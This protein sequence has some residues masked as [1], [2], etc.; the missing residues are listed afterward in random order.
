[1][2]RFILTCIKTGRFFRYASEG[3]ARQAAKTLGLKDFT[4]EAELET[5]P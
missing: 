2:G 5:S 3:Q 1:M 4:I